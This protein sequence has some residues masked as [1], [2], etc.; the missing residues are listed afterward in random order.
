MTSQLLVERPERPRPGA[1]SGWPLAVALILLSAIPLSAGMLRLIQLAGGPEFFSTDHRF[2][3]FPVALAAHIAGAAIFAFVGALQ[4]V[5][6]LRH[7]HWRWHRRA[8]RVLVLA[9]LLVVA[10]AVSLTLF[11]PAEPHTGHVLFAVRLVVAP[12][13][14]VCLVRGFV[15]IRRRDVASHRAWMI[16]AYALGLGAGTQV[17]TEPLGEALF[18]HGI[19][20]GDLEKT[21]GWIINFAIAEWAIR[22]PA[23]RH[24]TRAMPPAG[25]LS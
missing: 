20:A 22:R 16:R 14:A 11:Y 12:T 19:L 9:G 15:A 6:R 8:G 17:F 7:R 3:A 23:R 21:V 2:D 25:A 10:S 4:F 13:M 18:G 5:P 24:R 1:R